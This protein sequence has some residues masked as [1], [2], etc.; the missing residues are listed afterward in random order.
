MLWPHGLRFFSPDLFFSLSGQIFGF[1]LEAE[2]PI[3]KKDQQCVNLAACQLW[4]DQM[5][6]KS[7]KKIT[8]PKPIDRFRPWFLRSLK[9]IEACLPGSFWTSHGNFWTPW[10]VTF[11]MSMPPVN[12]LTWFFYSGNPSW[13]TSA[14]AERPSTYWNVNRILQSNNSQRDYRGPC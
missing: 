4:K 12:K 8:G 7:Q 3:K 10:P 14:D 6:S 1:I 11:D 5:F 9:Y 13:N 2:G